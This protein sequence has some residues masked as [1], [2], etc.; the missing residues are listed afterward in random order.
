MEL[1][2]GI[3]T[4]GAC[5]IGEMI[6]VTFI[7]DLLLVTLAGSAG[8]SA[9]VADSIRAQS[10]VT[11]SYAVFS[12]LRRPRRVLLPPLPVHHVCQRASLAFVGADV[13]ILAS[14]RRFVADQRNSGRCVLI[15]DHRG[16]P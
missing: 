15:R 1:R 5:F 11:R 9:T 2:R 13:A 16:S 12:Q 6:I 14:V 3:L 10:S 8:D 4:G 7:S